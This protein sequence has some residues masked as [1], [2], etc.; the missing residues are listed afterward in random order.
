MPLSL[1]FSPDRRALSRRE[2]KFCKPLQEEE[3]VRAIKNVLP[4]H[5]SLKTTCFRRPQMQ[6]Y[7]ACGRPL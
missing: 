5:Y 3:T 7:S 1:C 4:Y 6:R 2:Q